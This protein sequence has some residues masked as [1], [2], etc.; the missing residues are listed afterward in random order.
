MK[1]LGIGVFFR[2]VIATTALWIQ[3]IAGFLVWKL[4][5]SA[6]TTAVAA[7]GAPSAFL[8]PLFGVV[9]DRIAL[10]RSIN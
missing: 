6:W 5:G 2:V 7:A 3:R 4:S 1:L 9:V 10:R 8:G